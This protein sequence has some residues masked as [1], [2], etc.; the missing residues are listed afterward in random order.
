[1]LPGEF[2]EFCAQWSYKS[3]QDTGSLCRTDSSSLI[4]YR[5]KGDAYFKFQNHSF[6][7]LQIQLVLLLKEG[8]WILS[9]FQIWLLCQGTWNQQ[10]ADLV[11]SSPAICMQCVALSNSFHFSDL[12]FHLSEMAKKFVLP[13]P[14]CCHEA[15]VEGIE[16]MYVSYSNQ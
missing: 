13:L 10:T 9:R 14:W 5:R 12:T 11:S 8:I 6:K 7:G 4:G 16:N 15:T 3:S 1:M 2:S